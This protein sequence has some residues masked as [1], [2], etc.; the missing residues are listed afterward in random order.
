MND[1]EINT[2]VGKEILPHADELFEWRIRIYCEYPWLWV[3]NIDT[4]RSSDETKAFLSS[5]D[6]ILIK[7]KHQ[8]KLIGLSAG[9]SVRRECERY[10]K[11]FSERFNPEECFYYRESMLLPEYRNKGL[12]KIFFQEREKWAR[13]HNFVKQLMFISIEREENHPKKPIDYRSPIGLW[14][15]QGFTK[16][17]E[18]FLEADWVEV[19]ETEKKKNKIA[20]WVK[21]V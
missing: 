3:G 14:K 16:Q 1:L 8:G 18:M 17:S 4:E 20:F 2:Y 6:S 11:I 10:Q 9:N 15:S 12:Y 7:I 19:G 21:T 13:K 5:N